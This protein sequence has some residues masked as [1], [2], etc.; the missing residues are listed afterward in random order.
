M[1]LS[2]NR[3]G[4]TAQDRDF[5][6][7][8]NENWDKLEQSYNGIEQKVSMSDYSIVVTTPITFPLVTKMSG[9]ISSVISLTFGTGSLYLAKKS[10]GAAAATYNFSG[11]TKIDMVHN[12][13]LLWD[14]EANQLL[15]QDNNAVRPNSNILLAY[16]RE[17]EITDGFLAKYKNTMEIERINNIMEN[18]Q[19]THIVYSLKAPTIA[20][21][22]VSLKGSTLY[23][24]NKKG[25]AAKSYVGK[26]ADEFSIPHDNVL[27]WDFDSNALVVMPNSSP[28]PKNFILMAYAYQGEVTD[29][30]LL[31]VYTSNRLNNRHTHLVITNPNNV[32]VE[33]TKVSF[34]GCNLYAISDKATNIRA[35]SSKNTEEFDLIENQILIWDFDSNTFRVTDNNDTRP[36]SGF[37]VMA[38]A[39]SGLI[40]DGE[41][42]NLL[43]SRM[44]KDV[45]DIKRQRPYSHIV[46]SN[47]ALMKIQKGYVNLKGVNIFAVGYDA[48]TQKTYF[49]KGTEEFTLTHNQILIWDWDTNVLKVTGNNDSRPSRF[50]VL[51]YFSQSDIVAGELFNFKNMFSIQDSPPL[52]TESRHFDIESVEAGQGLT[53]MK[54]EILVFQASNSEHTDWASIIRYN[55]DTFEAIG[56]VQHNLGHAASVDYN[57]RKDILLIGNGETNVNVPSR[58]DFLTTANETIKTKEKI[59]ITNEPNLISIQFSGEGKDIGGSGAIACWGEQ[60][61]IIYLIVGQNKPTKIIKLLLGTGSHDFSDTSGTDNNRWGT[62]IPGKADG[63]INGTAKILQTFTGS[64]YGT[65]QGLTFHG[66]YLYLGL[67][68]EWGVTETTRVLKVQCLNN[69]TYRSVKTYEYPYLKADGSRQ[70]LEQEG[71][72]ILDGRYIVAGYVGNFGTTETPNWQNGWFLYPLNNK[73]GGKGVT[74]ATI[75]FKFKCNSIPQVKITSTSSV[76]DLYVS[77]VTTDGFKVISTSGGSGTFNWECEIS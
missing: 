15:V 52:S 34:K 71:V 67:T 48:I 6:N 46:F 62:F 59:D 61:N 74:G 53:V 44:N 45:S 31:K 30:A 23:A 63:E 25:T 11:T 66:G 73:Q 76:T 36:K 35:Y 2:L 16:H 22:Y 75:P 29:G 50:V 51:A 28:R 68:T 9:N 57:H 49:T 55:K 26:D 69:G 70:S 42:L 38:Y 21:N 13:V 18:V 72:A 56:T 37:I 12:S 27:L 14:L 32:V 7:K 47:W 58:L 8:T 3:W 65:F 39:R 1:A 19:E 41:I 17:G 4:N 54:E 64:E 77:E 43:I 33:G 20:G 60:D 10:G 24:I 40:T 5:R